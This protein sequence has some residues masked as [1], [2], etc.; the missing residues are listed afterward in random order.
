[1]LVS[2]TSMM[3]QV[4]P[5]DLPIYINVHR[6][7]FE[8]YEN[9]SNSANFDDSQSDTSSGISISDLNARMEQLRA[10]KTVGLFDK[11]RVFQHVGL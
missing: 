9:D 5:Q 8:G 4:S 6:T 10:P 7:T 2:L 3:T 11:I 1:M